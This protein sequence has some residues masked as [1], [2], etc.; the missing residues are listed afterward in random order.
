MICRRC[1]KNVDCRILDTIPYDYYRYFIDFFEKKI[2]S[3]PSNTNNNLNSYILV[4]LTCKAMLLL[5]NIKNIL[6][7]T[8]IASWQTRE[9]YEAVGYRCRY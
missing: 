6:S 7:K 3:F 5:Y 4:L 9:F 1:F 8:V 2:Y